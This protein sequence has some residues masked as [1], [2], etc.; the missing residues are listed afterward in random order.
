MCVYAKELQRIKSDRHVLALPR[1][2]D[3]LSDDYLET[4]ANV[5]LTTFN[6][7]AAGLEFDSFL[8]L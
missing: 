6:A 4:E 7:I 1:P 5:K 3:Q 8:S 2:H